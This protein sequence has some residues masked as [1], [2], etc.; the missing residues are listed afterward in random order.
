M[1]TMNSARLG[2]EEGL[3]RYG[4]RRIFVCVLPKAIVQKECVGN[5]DLVL[6]LSAEGVLDFFKE[7]NVC[8]DGSRP[9]TVVEVLKEV[10]RSGL[11]SNAAQRSDGREVRTTTQRSSG[12]ASVGRGRGKA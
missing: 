11:C 7:R 12:F 4:M 10:V 8:G 3:R 2:R 6:P 9:A 5:S 1:L